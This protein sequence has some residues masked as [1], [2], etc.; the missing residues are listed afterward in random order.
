LER[1]VDL[2]PQVALSLAIAY[3][4]LE[5]EEEALAMAKRAEKYFRIQYEREGPSN[6]ELSREA[7]EKLAEA[8]IL[9]GEDD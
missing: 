5:Q 6:P 8:L 4:N 7:A 2:H 3:R 1:V 9:R